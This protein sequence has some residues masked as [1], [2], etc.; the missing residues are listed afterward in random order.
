MNKAM[1]AAAIFGVAGLL[2]TLTLPFK[3][4]GD[5]IKPGLGDLMNGG[6]GM[7]LIILAAITAVVARKRMG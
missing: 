1:I 3:S 2:I 5:S 4:Y 7:A 6:I